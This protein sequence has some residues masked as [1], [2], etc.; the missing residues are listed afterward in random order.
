MANESKERDSAKDQAVVYIFII[1]TVGLLSYAAI[2]PWVEQ[3][4]EV[5]LIPVE[6][7]KIIPAL[8]SG[9][10]ARQRRSYIPVSGQGEQ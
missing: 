10:R 3:W 2:R 1:A 5:G 7:M 8:T 6:F 4:T 9:Q